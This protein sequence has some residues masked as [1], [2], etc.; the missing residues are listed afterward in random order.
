MIV[1]IQLDDPVETCRELRLNDTV[2]PEGEIA[3][4][5]E[6]LPLNPP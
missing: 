1:R 3:G 2:G 5:S 6:T 4:E